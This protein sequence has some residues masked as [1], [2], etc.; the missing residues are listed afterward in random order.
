M[1][2]LKGLPT[3]RAGFFSDADEVDLVTRTLVLAI[4]LA[5]LWIFLSGHL[6]PL[7]LG[8]GAMSVVLA[9]LIALRL[10]LLDDESLPVAK[11][12]H[13]LAFWLWLVPK[14]IASSLHVVRRVLAPRCKVEPQL[15][16]V[17]A[18]DLSTIGHVSY[19][20]ALTLTPGTVSLEVTVDAITVHAL[21]R[22]A[23]EDLRQGGMEQRVRR[24][25]QGG[26]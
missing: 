11:L 5:L 10:D 24:A 6:E 26:V 14:V 21:T 13:L 2:P 4:L 22:H 3:R 16:E 8:F 17:P 18:R 9:C 20:N 7:L 1:S 19:A 23:V 12:P 25:D 15:L